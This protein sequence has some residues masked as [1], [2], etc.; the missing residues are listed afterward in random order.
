MKLLRIA[1]LSMFL[2]SAIAFAG[3]RGY[4]IS[5]NDE[6]GPLIEFDSDEVTA[7][8]KVTEEELLKNVTA[9]DEKDGDVTASLLIESISDFISSGQRIITYA[10]FDSNNNITKRERKLIYTDYKSPRF[11]LKR[12]LRFT[13]GDTANILEY[14]EVWDCIDGDLSENIKYEEPDYNFGTTEDTYQITFQVTN[15]AGDTA[16]LPAEIEF[17]YMEKSAPEILLSKYLIYLKVGEAFHPE[18]YIEGVSINQKKYGIMENSILQSGRPDNT[19]PRK[20]ISIS[21]NVNIRKPG[22]YQAEYSMTAQNG[23]R[24]RTKLLV[25]VEE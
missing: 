7:G 25:V 10:A 3:Y 8:V 4:E 14:M 22:V 5:R 24:G 15:S 6:A 2:L 20:D 18:A 23:N 9:Y 11:S 13:V 1:G 21:S 17:Y 16:Y 19:I 12:P